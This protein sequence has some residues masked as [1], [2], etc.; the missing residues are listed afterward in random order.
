MSTIAKSS[1]HH[2]PF[3]VARLA[4]GLANFTTAAARRARRAVAAW[5]SRTDVARLARLDERMLAD[6]GLTGADIRDAIARPRWTD[7]T[8]M[9]AERRRERQVYDYRAI[10]ARLVL[11]RNSIPLAPAAE[12]TGERTVTTTH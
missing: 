9:L 8:A 11:E 6:M 10:F 1:F 3:G 2:Q 5:K 7:A 4:Q 12:T